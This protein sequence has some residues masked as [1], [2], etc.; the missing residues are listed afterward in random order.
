MPIEYQ[1]TKYEKSLLKLAEDEEKLIGF[2]GKY[3]LP[4]KQRIQL[5]M[6]HEGEKAM[7]LK[8]MK[9]LDFSPQ[10]KKEL[11]WNIWSE[12][13]PDSVEEV[14]KELENLRFLK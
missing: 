3:T 2:D 12:G 5:D 14:S 1:L 11:I 8:V 4:D 9:V 10:K 6:F 13:N 7:L